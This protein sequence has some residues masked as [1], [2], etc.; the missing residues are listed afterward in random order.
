MKK[1][2][3]LLRCQPFFLCGDSVFAEIPGGR[4]S[5][6]GKNRLPGGEKLKIIEKNY[7]TTLLK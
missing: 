6:P 5:R 7:G 3:A 1:R 2:L 4:F